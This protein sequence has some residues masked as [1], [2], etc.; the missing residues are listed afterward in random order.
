MVLL[1]EE[2]ICVLCGEAWVAKGIMKINTKSEETEAAALAMT[3]KEREQVM[4]LCDGCSG[5]YHMVC[6][7]CFEVP[8][9]DWYCDFCRCS[10]MESEEGN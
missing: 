5:S 10:E 4:L 2:D 6:V 8:E 3:D 1:E 9:G 7:G